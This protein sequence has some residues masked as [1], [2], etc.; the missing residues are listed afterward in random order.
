MT[1]DASAGGFA[2]VAYDKLASQFLHTE[3]AN[4]VKHLDC[5]NLMRAMY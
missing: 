4:K 1:E 5:K 2:I 3:Y